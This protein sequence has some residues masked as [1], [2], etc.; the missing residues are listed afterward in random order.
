MC[1]VAIRTVN[2]LDLSSEGEKSLARHWVA[3][4]NLNTYKS[5]N[6][7]LLHLKGL[8]CA[9]FN[10]NFWFL[11][12]CQKSNPLEPCHAENLKTLNKQIILEKVTE[13]L[14]AHYLRALVKIVQ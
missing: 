9:L 8:G 1:T 4:D 11:T 5:Q 3:S 7:Q 6:C 12:L 14:C 2:Q 13:P 10:L